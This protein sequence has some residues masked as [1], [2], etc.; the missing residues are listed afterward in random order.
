MSDIN[1][2]LPPMISGFGDDKLFAECTKSDKNGHSL[3]LGI[4]EDDKIITIGGRQ[5]AGVGGGNMVVLP[6]LTSTWWDIARAQA[7]GKTV[8]L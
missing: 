8:Y 7:E 1:T 3:E 4:S 6:G 5:I 2:E